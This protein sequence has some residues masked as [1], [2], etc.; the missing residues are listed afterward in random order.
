MFVDV[1]CICCFWWVG[2]FVFVCLS[3]CIGC[4]YVVW[5]SDGVVCYFVDCVVV[6]WICVVLFGW[7]EICY[8]RCCIGWW[9]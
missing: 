6:G 1:G 8:Y 4:W 7:V 9:W 5:V 3:W 2:V